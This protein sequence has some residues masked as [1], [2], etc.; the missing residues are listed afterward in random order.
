[1]DGE[2]R[3]PVASVVA[4]DPEPERGKAPAHGGGVGVGV[5]ANDHRARSSGPE[6]IA[7]PGPSGPGVRSGRTKPL[8]AAEERPQ[9]GP[10]GQQ[11]GIM[12]VLVDEQ[13]VPCEG[14][15]VVEVVQ[16]VAR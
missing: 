10:G 12:P 2:N 14:R 3:Q 16:I 4:V 1:M 15:N 8:P 6:T 11:P 7:S 9:G 5:Q 13:R